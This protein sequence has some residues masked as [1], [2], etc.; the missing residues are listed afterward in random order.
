MKKSLLFLL[1]IIT[2]S[3]F[4]QTD[5]SRMQWFNDAKLGIF[6]HWGMYAVD[7]T[8]ESWAFHNGIVPYDQYM[9]QMKRFNPTNFNAESWA[10][11]VKESGAKYV[12]V[13]AQHHD[14]LALWNTKQLTPYPSKTEW[15]KFFPNSSYPSG[16]N[17]LWNAK[18][19]LSTVYQTPAKKDLITPLAAAFR[20]ENLK[21]GTYYS[22]LDW[23]HSNYPGFMKEAV[24]RYEIA[25][26]PEK[27]NLFLYFMHAQI[28]EL[29]STFK[30][31]L[32]WF[33][34]DWEH[35]EK[36][37]GA[38]KIDSIIHTTNPNAI[39]NGRLPTYG[40]YSTPEQNMP[41]TH[42]EKKSWELCLTS[43]DSWGFQPQDTNFKTTNEVLQIF[44]ECL[45]MGGNLLLDIGPKADGTIP[46]QQVQLLKEIGRWA[47]KHSEAIYG[48]TAGLPYGH[49]HGNSA[50]SADRKTIYLFVNQIRPNG[51]EDDVTVDL[52]LKGIKNKIVS[53]SVIGSRAEIETKIVGKIAWSWVPGTVFIRIPG[54]LLDK[55]I[56]V[57]KII[58]DSPLDLYEGKGGFH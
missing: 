49:Y 26:D 15:S 2:S 14:G 34:G 36:E 46:E 23:S 21:F 48:T 18:L 7:G 55:E 31:D 42:P 38:D 4:A 9:N 51:T 8:S 58:L 53:A 1:L 39:L 5:S 24:N 27:W 13:T 44:T 35:S 57:V 40:D 54:V 12:V 10:K 50:L 28:A 32:Y 45:N 16:K 17:A 56:T 25:N 30:P 41:I 29:N 37:W 11:L 47:S 6:I 20:K 43:N 22:L 19:P 33:D 3:V 52:M